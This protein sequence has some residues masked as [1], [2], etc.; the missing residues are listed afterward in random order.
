MYHVWD[1]TEWNSQKALKVWN[2]SAW[3]KTPK[4]KVRT[5]ISWLPTSVSDTDISQIVKWS[6]GAPTPPPPPPPVTHP[7]PDLDLMDD[8][9]L[10]AALTPLNFGYNIAGYEVTSILANDNKVVIDS[11]IPAAG[12]LMAE[13][14]NVSIKLYNFVQPTT[15]VP[16]LDG[17]LTSAANSAITG[18]NLVV[19]TP[20]TEEKTTDPNL[21]GK[22]KAGSQ[23]PPAGDVVDTQTSVTYTK[24]IEEDKVTIPNNLTG[25]DFFTMQSRLTEVGLE[26]GTEITP[27][28]ETDA[29]PTGPAQENLVYSTFP[30]AG[31]QV[32]IGS[33][34]QYRMRIPNTRTKIPNVIGMSPYNAQVE[35]ENWDLVYF[36]Y[37]I[38]EGGPSAQ[39]N[40][41][42]AQQPAANSSL[43]ATA[44]GTQ[45]NLTIQVPNTTTF[46]PYIINQTV[47]D[48]TTACTVNELILN[49]NGPTLTPTETTNTSL[50]GKIASQ[51][52]TQNVSQPIWSWVNYGIYV[53][54][55]T[56]TVP[57]LQYQI[58]GAYGTAISVEPQLKWGTLI[59][60]YETTDTNLQGKVVST[61]P[62][63]GQVVTIGSYISYY[64]WIAPVLK[65]MPNIV[66]QTEATAKTMIN[67]AGLNWNTPTTQ[68]LTS[69]QSS[70]L[71]GTVASQGTAPGVQLNPGTY[72]NFVVYTAYVPQPVTKYGYVTIGYSADIP[73]EWIASYKL[74]AGSGAGTRERTSAPFY[75][76][77][78]STTNGKNMQ[79]WTFN[80]ASFTSRC[81]TVSGGA[82][83]TVNNVEFRYWVNGGSGNDTAKSLRLGS[84]PADVSSSPTTMNESAVNLRG[85]AL[86]ISGRGTYGYSNLSSQL[87]SDCFTAPNYPLVI[88]APNTSID[89][90]VSNDADVRFTVMIQW[91]EY[92]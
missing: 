91:T 18:A 32:Y 19:G 26:I 42:I 60:S 53:P 64:K 85:H 48:A 27:G 54:V 16:N 39:D 88:Y 73:A 80:W 38:Q 50:H 22:V 40:T 71:V 3:V 13:G 83:W 66:G 23:Y 44:V 43:T 4:F 37:I 31:T 15:T 29:G 46:V 77:Q 65:T 81:N 51:D 63:S 67:N 35:L 20:I 49:P 76:G 74:T 41:V 57:D 21:F 11:Q 62:V 30:T 84:Y 61:S 70:S 12:E 28:F 6:V 82:A 92:Q 1:G 58:P 55:T 2:G 45:I 78:F 9:A 90:Y 56:V 34:V 14:L 33:Q 8:A 89:N 52:P 7:L 25:V 72:V 24:W 5:S 75:V 69:T 87:I 79:A 17:L 10:D 86:N 36:E 68:A 47:Q 59:A